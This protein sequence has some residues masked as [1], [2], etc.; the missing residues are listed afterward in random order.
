MRPRLP[1]LALLLLAA[2]LA[3]GHAA[4]A[5]PMA[6]APAAPAAAA[7]QTYRVPYRLTDTKHLLVRAKLNGKGPFHFIIDTGAPTLFV[8][9][10][11]AAKAGVTGDNESWATVARLEIE[12]GPVLENA[13][14]RVEEPP[15]LQGMNAMG[16]AGTRMDGVIGYTVLARFRT[17]IDLTQRTMA[18]TR[19]NHEPPPLA[20]IAELLNGKPAPDPKGVQGLESV[21]KL[22]SA[23]FKRTPQEVAARGFL[24]LE[25]AEDPKAAR[26]RAVLP[27]GPAA[28]AGLAAGDRI[29]S[30]AVGAGK[31]QPVAAGAD[32]V[33]VAGAVVAGERLQLGV[34]RGSK[35]LNLTVTAGKGGL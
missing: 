4:P 6:A 31:P 14:A 35:R 16:L 24:G 17:E 1:L 18:W 10:A 33:R 30:A 3:Q 21:A 2:P 23:L 9:K 13:Q 20:G 25:L 32:L 12:G 8:S 29:I 11:A 5:A 7:G 28:Q 15:Q 22:A 34:L 19:L 26:V 27:K